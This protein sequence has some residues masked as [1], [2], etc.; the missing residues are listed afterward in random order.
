MD[1]R[2]VDGVTYG[3]YTEAAIQLRLLES[4]QIFI[5]AMNDALIDKPSLRQ[6][7]Q[8]FAMLIFHGG[9]TDPQSMFDKFLDD[10]YPPPAAPHGQEPISQQLRKDE[11]MRYLEYFFNS[12]GTKCG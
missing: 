4:D 9:P 12:M 6:L 11:V 8:Y 2:M 3:T 1:L 10:L 7:R 5:D